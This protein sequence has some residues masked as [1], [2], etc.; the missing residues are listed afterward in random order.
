MRQRRHQRPRQQVRRNHREHDR[1]GQRDEQEARGAL[2]HHH[3]EEDDADGDGGGER[4]HG[5]LVRAVEDRDGEA[6]AEAAVAV[7]VLDLDGG[8]VDQHAD[9]ER[10]AAERQGRG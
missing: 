6:F 5:D 1:D 8:V 9:G 7:D 2:Q 10:E 4:G 3:R